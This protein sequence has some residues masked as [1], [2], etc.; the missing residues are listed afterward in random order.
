[1]GAALPA[2]KPKA[3]RARRAHSTTATSLL[4]PD[5]LVPAR[6]AALAVEKRPHGR[7]Q[8]GREKDVV[9]RLIGQDREAVARHV[10]A[11]PARVLPPAAPELV[12]A[13]TELGTVAAAD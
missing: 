6:L 5:L 2:V 7:H 12:E 11:P 1:M 13:H 3:P 10:L 9:V 4:F 8:R